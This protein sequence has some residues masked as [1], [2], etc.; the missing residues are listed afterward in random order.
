MTQQTNKSVIGLTTDAMELRAAEV[1]R[2][3][4]GL[5]VT[6]KGC[7][8]L[9]AGLITDGGIADLTAFSAAVG[10]LLKGPGFSRKAPL[11]IGVKNQ[12]A[13]LRIAA[14][15]KLPPDKMKNAVLL[16]AQPVI[17]I[18]VSELELDC[19][20]ENEFQDENRTMVS[21]LLTGAK[22]SH[23][24][25]LIYAAK[26]AERLIGDVDIAILATQRAV[27]DSGASGEECVL[28]ADIDHETINMLV[29]CGE[30]IYMA[31]T[32]PL[33]AEASGLLNAPG[34]QPMNEEQL[35]SLAPLITGDLRTS[36]RYFSTL[37]AA[38][39]HP[40]SRVLLT[41]C[42][43]QTGQLGSVMASGFEL[44]VQVPQLYPALQ[45]AGADALSYGTV[46]SLALRGLEGVAR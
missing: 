44:P 5:K 1:E 35:S 21:T 25:H 20:F 38:A 30:T 45:G 13:L 32:V 37:P 27:L 3:V 6:A 8:P 39:D 26:A 28:L 2:G 4:G 11:L 12:N 24:N 7:V 15:P 29:F 9:P 42:H 22:K 33:S 18:P 10:Q 23:L 34:S 43:P 19:L 36:L 31:R 40:V 16:Q 14:F 17:P 46:I 41:G